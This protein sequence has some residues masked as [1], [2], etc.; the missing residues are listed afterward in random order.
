[1]SS[2]RLPSGTQCQKLHHHLLLPDT[3]PL[4]LWVECFPYKTRTFLRSPYHY[5]LSASLCQ[6]L[7][8]VLSV[9]LCLQVSLWLILTPPLGDLSGTAPPKNPLALVWFVGMISATAFLGSNMPALC[10]YIQTLTNPFLFLWALSGY[11]AKL[12]LHLLSIPKP[13]NCFHGCM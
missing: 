3:F 10:C 5:S 4:L 9:S 2:T 6:S 12:W 8:L 1:M 7:S 13:Y 11:I